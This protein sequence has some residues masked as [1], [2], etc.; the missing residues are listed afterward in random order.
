MIDE[1]LTKF[2]G[3]EPPERCQCGQKVTGELCMHCGAD[4]LITPNFLSLHFINL[5][6]R[7]LSRDRLKFE[8]Y[9]LELVEL[10]REMPEIALVRATPSEKRAKLYKVVRGNA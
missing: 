8:K 9:L 3:I 4:T 2:C 5:A 10:R 6:E 1:T 7:I